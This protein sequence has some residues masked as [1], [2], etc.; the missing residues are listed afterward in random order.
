MR[1]SFRYPADVLFHRRRCREE[2]WFFPRLDRDRRRESLDLLRGDAFR[3]L[4]RDLKETRRD[5]E[6]DP[7]RGD[8]RLFRD[9]LRGE[10]EG[11]ELNDRD[12]CV[13]DRDRDVR[14]PRMERD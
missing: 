8:F 1:S 4:F 5:R 10:R 9:R 11:E 6:R 7:F 2:N 13:R 3:D 12:S 14:R